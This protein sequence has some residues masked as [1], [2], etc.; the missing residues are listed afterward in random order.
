MKTW[1]ALVVGV[2]L[3]V[4]LIGALWMYGRLGAPAPAW[5]GPPAGRLVAA[6]VS[7]PV[8]YDCLLAFGI[9]TYQPRVLARPPRLRGVRR[10]RRQGVRREKPGATTRSRARPSRACD[11]T[12]PREMPSASAVAASVR[13]SK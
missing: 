12:A 4:Q 8:A 7:L 13:S 1:L 3:L 5:V 10:S 6:G 2:L 11:F 9:Q